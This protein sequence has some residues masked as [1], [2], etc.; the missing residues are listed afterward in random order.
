[1][2]QPI[3]DLKTL[4]LSRAVVSEQELRDA[5]PHRAEFQLLDAVVHFDREGGIAVG[6]KDWDH[7]PWWAKGHVPG[8]PLMPGVLMLEGAAQIATF[9][10]KQV[11]GWSRDRMIGLAGID[12][13]RIRGQVVPPA[14]VWFVSSIVNISGRRLAK[15]RTEVFCNDQLILEAKIM[16]VML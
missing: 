2:G 15:M 6:Y 11:S 12:E 5:L 10:V 4:D 3:V 8:R 16:G 13:V 7:D 9:L 1:M 14:R